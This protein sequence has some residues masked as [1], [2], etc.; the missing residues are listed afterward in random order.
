MRRRQ[1]SQHGF[2]AVTQREQRAIGSCGCVELDGHRKAAVV[3][4]HRQ[5]QP[6]QAGGAAELYVRAT[7]VSKGIGRPRTST[8]RSSPIR[9]AGTRV[10]GNTMAATFVRAKYSRYR[11]R[12]AGRC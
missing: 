8:V 3:E 11:V 7:T 2:G 1:A 12:R 9:G 5:Y 6:R 4:S 10:A